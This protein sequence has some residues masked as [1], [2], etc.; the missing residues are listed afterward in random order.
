MRWT[1]MLVASLSVAGVVGA[2]G[3][4]PEA[5]SEGETWVSQRAGA[6]KALWTPE[7]YLDAQP[8]ELEVDE[9]LLLAKEIGVS[10][11]E[12]ETPSVQLGISTP[13]RYD[14][15][16]LAAVLIDPETASA[17]VAASGDVVDKAVGIS[18]GHF[19]SAQVF[20]V[21][22]E[23]Y[24][25]YAPTGR[26]F[27]SKPNGLTYVC[28]GSVIAPRLVLTAGHCV[29]SGFAN[30]FYSDFQFVP[31]YREGAAPNGVWSWTRV[32]TTQAWST[33]KAK[34]PNAGDLAIIEIEDQ[35]IGGAVR[36]IGELTGWYAVA[37]QKLKP[38]HLHMLG[39]PVGH[40]GGEIMHQCIS[41][42]AR[43]YGLKNEAYGCDMTGGSSGGP[44]IQ[45]FGVP[46]A[47]QTSPANPVVVG[48]TS[49]GVVQPA[50]FWILA[51]STPDPKFAQMR[52]A[53]CASQPGN[54]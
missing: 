33:G 17:R 30:G 53:A 29:H 46:S 5:P 12:A 15:S 41:A 21:N 23:T 51:S 13:P 4:R 44:W 54:C 28:S 14:G 2:A 20:P 25:P 49:W 52:N 32:W 16:A 18:K 36:R 10:A 42:H 38:N 8:I 47:G 11:V 48:V 40:D 22:L 27:F 31:S 45:N 1:M 26:L 37:T 43:G 50:K 9:D 19:T 3:I 7:M 35:S 24:W 6:E 34:I 39:Y